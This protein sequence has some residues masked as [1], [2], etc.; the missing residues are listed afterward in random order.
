MLGGNIVDAVLGDKSTRF[1]IIIS[2]TE[3]VETEL[4]IVVVAAVTNGIDVA[5]LVEVVLVMNRMIAPGIVDIA[6]HKQAVGV[7][8]VG[9]IT[10]EILA[11]EIGL[12]VIDKA[13]DTLYS[14]SLSSSSKP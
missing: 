8:D 7:V 13:Y 4:V 14:S 11:I 10:K 12:T 1:R 3:I 5:D 9:H 2:G 6:C